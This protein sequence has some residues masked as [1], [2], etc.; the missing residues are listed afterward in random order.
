MYICKYRYRCVC[1]LLRFLRTGDYRDSYILETDATIEVHST[2]LPRK[3]NTRLTD[4]TPEGHWQHYPIL[5]ECRPCF[6]EIIPGTGNTT[7]YGWNAVHVLRKLFLEYLHGT[8]EYS[9][10]VYVCVR[11]FFF[12]LGVG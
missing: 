8:W 12:Q 7:Q 2:S 11:V 1:G 9:P 6:T 3:A 4:G 10:C 5:L